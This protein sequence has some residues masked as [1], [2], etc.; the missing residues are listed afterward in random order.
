MFGLPFIN[1]NPAL[2]DFIGALL[3]L[4]VVAIVMGFHFYNVGQPLS[5]ALECA[6]VS[7]GEHCL[8]A[9]KFSNAFWDKYWLHDV[10]GVFAD[11]KALKLA[12]LGPNA[13]AIGASPIMAPVAAPAAGAINPALHKVVPV[14]KQPAAHAETA[15]FT[16]DSSAKDA[17]KDNWPAE[18]KI[19]HTYR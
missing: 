18:E 3:L 1:K 7:Q 14:P 12:T 2:K 17:T 16:L 6:C 8:E 11:V 9:H 10:P 19:V 15:T 13:A 4:I 5:R